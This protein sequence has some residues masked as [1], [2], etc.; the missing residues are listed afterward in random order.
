MTGVLVDTHTFAW[1]TTEPERL[2][3][4]A[5]MLIDA[6]D[7]TFVSVVSLYEIGQKVRL[8]KW[9]EMARTVRTLAEEAVAIN[10]GLLP[11]TPPISLAAGLLDWPHRDPF[12]RMIAATALVL[13]LV[14]VSADT[15]FDTLP[16]VRRVW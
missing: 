4:S 11:L 5:R 13:D 2:T 8:G 3:R 9:P 7:Q 15:A 6:A 10:V 1:I 14:L 12:D 16:E